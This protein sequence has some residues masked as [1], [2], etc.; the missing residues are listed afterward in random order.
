MKTKSILKLAS[1]LLLSASA[2]PAHAGDVKEL[3]EKNC[4]S[5][6]GKDGRGD[7]K[8]GRKV[9]AKDYT[10]PKVQAAMKDEEMFKAI[11]EGLKEG[12]KTKMKAHKDVLTDEEIKALVQ[13]VRAFK[14]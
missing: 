7:T 1:I 4:V 8:M 2:G 6:H 3:W 13:Y 10:D 12:G 9:G 14:K 5:C 11:K